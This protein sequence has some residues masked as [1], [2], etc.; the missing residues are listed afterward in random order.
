VSRLLDELF[1]VRKGERPLTGLL[2][3]H[4]LFAVGAFV[5]GRAVRDA[6]FLSHLGADALAQ[7]YVLSAVAVALAG[8][9]YGPLAARFRRDLL[10]LV[11]ATLF[12]VLFAVAY[13]A[14]RRG[15]AWFYPAL[16]VYVEVMGAITLLQFWTL[17]NELFHAREAKRLYGIIGS[18][19]TLANVLVGVATSRIAVHFG[20]SAVLLLCAALLFGCAAASFW[21]G[22][23]GR[24]RLFA[25]AARGA[26]RRSRNAAGASRVIGSGHLRTVALLAAITFFTTTLVDFEFKAIA[27]M[28]F[29][30]D[31]L[32]EYFGNFYAVVGVGALLI[33]LFGTSRMLARAGVLAALL[34]LPLSLGAGNVLLLLF[35]ALWAA[36]GAKGADTLFRYTINDATT[37]ILYLP[38]PPHARASAKAFIDSVVKSCAIGLAGVFLFVHARWFHGS[39]YGV[40]KVAVACCGAWAAV[41]WVLRRQYIRSLQDNLRSRSL[42]LDSMRHPVQDGSTG[43]VLQKALASGNT[44]EILSALE[45]LPHLSNIQLDHQVEPL[46]DSPDP[47]VRLATLRYYAQRQSMRYANSIFRR[48]EDPEPAVR[49]AAVDA[50]CQIGRDRAVRSVRMFLN[51]ADPA[52]RAA[53]VTG[54]IRFGGLDGVLAAAE[55]LKQLIGH[56]QAAMREHAAKVLK[57]IGVKNFYQPVLELMNDPVPSVRRAAIGAAAALHS[58][59]FVIPLIYKT[60]SAETGAEAIEALCA[61]GPSIAQ[62]LGKAL[63]NRLEDLAIRRSVARVLGRL[64]TPEAVNILLPHLDEPDEE[65]RLRLYRA[66][67]R[68]AKGQRLQ[69]AA[70]RQVDSALELELLRAYR[71]LAA[72][73]ALNLGPGPGPHTPR[74]GP[75]AAQALL[76]V[77]ITDKISRAERR[78]FLLLAVRHPEAGMEHIHAGLGEAGEAQ[79]NRRR[80]NAVELLDNLLE[81]RLKR[82][83][84]PLV[85]DTGRAEKLRAAAETLALTTPT[86]ALALEELTRDENAWVRACALHLAA[87][88]CSPSA[89]EAVSNGLTDPNPIVRETALLCAVRLEPA[90]TRELAKARLGDDS[91]LVRRHASRLAGAA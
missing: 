22:R 52:V 13:V 85:E 33:Q 69:P 81:R 6:L 63:S 86:P 43:K 76:S 14:E 53:A 42:D 60:Q 27:G 25:K 73:E 91:Q 55:A 15:G 28:T 38:V 12:G 79:S 89:A 40:A 30:K 46:L 70:K 54:M 49:A 31:R 2:F 11:T 88:L 26:P 8:L 4:S 10:A 74:E 47:A 50:F 80:A 29:P 82:R 45:L 32:A 64:G 67:A 17:S 66:L 21:A 83:F 39:P 44:P 41:L 62:T 24:E 58:P 9:A 57:A 59:E 1:P 68:A 75:A 72:A 56:E 23:L 18:G 90:R 48:F 20:A 19:G 65:L 36:A 35:P 3:L 78:M 7:M 71:A 61:Y 5:A 37:Q 16:Y 84:L 51:D 87:A 77:A 34:V